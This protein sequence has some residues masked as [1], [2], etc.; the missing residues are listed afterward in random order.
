MRSDAAS[1]LHADFISHFIFFILKSRIVLSPF[2]IFHDIGIFE[3]CG[4]A[5]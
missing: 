2:S 1:V 3:E 5:L 4:M